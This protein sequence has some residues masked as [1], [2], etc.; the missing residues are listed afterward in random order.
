M[1]I[2]IC[3]LSQGWAADYFVPQPSKHLFSEIDSTRKGARQRD[4]FLRGGGEG[5]GGGF[6][7]RD[8][9]TDVRAGLNIT[10]C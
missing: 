9:I 5:E 3:E 4:V 1:Y 7:V 10:S 6:E 8:S 2:Y